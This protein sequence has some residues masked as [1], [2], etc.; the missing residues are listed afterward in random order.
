MKFDAR[1][2]ISILQL[3]VF[4]PTSLISLYLAK[5][6]SLRRSFAW[7]LLNT[8]SLIRVVGACFQLTTYSNPSTTIFEIVVILDSI[9][10]SPLLLASSALISRWYVTPPS[11]HH[12]I[13]P[14]YLPNHKPT[15]RR[16][17]NPSINSKTLLPRLQTRSIHILI[18]AATALAIYGG[19]HAIQPNDRTY[20]P[21]T[22]SKM[23]IVLYIVALAAVSTYGFSAAITI[24]RSPPPSPSA[25]KQARLIFAVLAALPFILVRLVYSALT[26]FL[27]NHAFSLIHGSVAIWAVMAVVEEIVVVGVYMF[28]GLTTTTTTTAASLGLGGDEGRRGGGLGTETET[29]KV[30]M[31]EEEGATISYHRGY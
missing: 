9:G 23:G 13:P 25:P 15:N 26:V 5:R 19:T 2:G 18:I 28:A 27:H 4:F 20:R 29:K 3:A 11:D 1:G 22:T 10:V 24:R 17:D 6:W 7:I 31:V 21:Q 14:A 30:A 8:F 16:K 12:S